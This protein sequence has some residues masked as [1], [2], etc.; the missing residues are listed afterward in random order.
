[1]RNLSGSSAAEQFAVVAIVTILVT[2]AYLEATGYPQVGGGD[3]HIAHAL[4]GGALMMIA[5]LVGWALIGYGARV[6]AIAAGG[7]GFGLFLDEVGK[8]VTKDNDYFY[9]PSAEIMFVLVVLVIVGGR[10]VRD[11]RPLNAVEMLASANAIA[12]EGLAHGL[13]DYR[14][15][16][17]H[18]LLTR[19][20]AAGTDAASIAAVRALVDAA[21][22]AGDRLYRVHCWTR[23]HVER[24]FTSPRWVPILGW[25]MVASAAAGLALTVLGVV[26]GRLYIDDSAAPEFAGVSVAQILS[27]IVAVVVLSLALPA[28]VARR[29]TR[30]LWPLR[31][32]RMA[33]LVGLLL[34]AF[35]DFATEGF[36]ALLGVATGLFSLAVLS[37]H[38]QRALDDPATTVR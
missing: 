37:L 24:W 7:V 12:T 26:V 8:F 10:A 36:G 2:R 14:R 5:L 27:G 21:P 9:A 16:T 32:L 11:L 3:L 30:G 1:M 22:Q 6:F 20:A 25:L 38:L 15:E 35:I 13:A 31:M 18:T 4:Y 17:A 34:N 28:L 33:A 29:R 23:D 19:S